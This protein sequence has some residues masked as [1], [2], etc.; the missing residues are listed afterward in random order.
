MSASACARIASNVFERWLISRIDIP[1]PGS[2]MRSRWISSRTGSGMTAGPAEKLKTRC[3]AV[4]VSDAD[5]MQ[6]ENIRVALLHR[7]EQRVRRRAVE[8]DAGDGGVSAL[9]D[10]VLGFLHVDVPA[11]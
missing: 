8:V 1:T 2:A 6:I 3:I 10:D 7:I 11:A 9:E 4:M 5:Q